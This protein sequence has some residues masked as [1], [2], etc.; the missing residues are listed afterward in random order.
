[1]NSSVAF[2][3]HI[4]A[5]RAHC[6]IAVQAIRSLVQ[7]Q[8][9]FGGK[10]DWFEILIRPHGIHEGKSPREFVDRLYYERPPQITDIEILER[11]TD[12]ANSRSNPTR[13]SVNAHP[14]S[15]TCQR[16][17]ACVSA[18]NSE[19][20]KRGHSLCL[21]LVEYGACERKR[22]MIDNA[23]KLRQEGVLIALDD[24][25]SGVNCFDLCAAGIVDLL[26]IDV[27]LVAGIETNPN[28][29]A[30]VHS[31]LTLGRGL[32]AKVVAEGVETAA[33]V[34]TLSEMGADFAQGFKFHKPQRVEA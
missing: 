16:F 31:I 24:F 15:L 22:A 7:G 10:H 18:S 26:K 20:A 33:Q 27:G 19:L 11:A 6:T 9:G 12:W 32:G 34:T 28:Q 3:P 1:M 2:A 25:G 23:Q 29:R 30:L 14:N 13:I 8:A 4:T 17:I 5:Q 21:E